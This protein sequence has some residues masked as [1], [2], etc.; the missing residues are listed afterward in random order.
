[1]TVGATPPLSKAKAL[2][3]NVIPVGAARNET[4]KLIFIRADVEPI[5]IPIPIIL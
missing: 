1:V 5:A 3:V 4:G 2:V